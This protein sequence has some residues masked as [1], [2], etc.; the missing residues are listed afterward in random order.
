MIL[1]RQQSTNKASKN[2]NLNKT[3][4]L[5]RGHLNQLPHL[6]LCTALSNHEATLLQI[7][8]HKFYVPHR[9]QAK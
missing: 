5:G 4:A 3:L 1:S 7:A 6:K 9:L 8:T 2:P